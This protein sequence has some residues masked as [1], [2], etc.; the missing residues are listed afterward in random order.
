[1]YVGTRK[2][3]FV[4]QAFHLRARLGSLL[5]IEVVAC[6]LTTV[7]T[8]P[9]YAPVVRVLSYYDLFEY[10][11]RSDEIGLFLP[12]AGVSSYELEGSLA[13]MV[14]DGKIR[15]VKGYYFL[16]HRESSVVERRIAME[17]HGN[18]MWRIARLMTSLMRYTPF[19]R[20]VFISGQLCRY[21]A[22]EQSDIDYFIV[23]EPRRLWIVRTLFVL[24]RRTLLFN[25]RK[26]FCTNY[27][28]TA[29]N[30][31]IK[32]RNPYV[33][34]EVAS[35]KPIYNREIFDRF[36][37]ENDWVGEFYPNFSIERIEI[38]RGV[39][40]G[41]RFR[42]LLECLIPARLADRLDKRLMETTRKFWRRKFPGLDARA[43]ESSLRTRRDESR[44]HPNDQA[45]VVLER[46]NAG[47]RMYGISDE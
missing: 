24:F 45:P 40:G 47:L 43:Y 9:L 11:L 16:P 37:E 10:P 12:V 42:R 34:C 31:T 20:G 30:L 26:Y 17:E 8:Y 1:M 13:E 21:I 32:E 3:I 4:R 18:R 35:L 22:D 39:E 28:V 7:D 14:A 15:K 6:M 23:T 29:D 44:A 2:S 33:A 41:E 5:H 27:Y 38:R 36:I 46:Y 25:S 19:V